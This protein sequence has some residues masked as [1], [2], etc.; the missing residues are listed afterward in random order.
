[1][2]IV[3]LKNHPT[4]GRVGDVREVP[5]GYAR[6]F[7]I[8]QGIA[9]EATKN[10][11][12]H[13][14]AVKH[15]KDV[16]KKRSGLDQK[17][18]MRALADLTLNMKEKADEKGTFFAGITKEKIAAALA[19]K[20]LNVKLKQIVLTEPV[21]HAGTYKVRIIFDPSNQVV[22]NLVVKNEN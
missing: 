18:L 11:V 16:E 21:K 22:V 14:E 9:A 8:P 19:K 6:N 10:N 4:A 13:A 15:R 20:N 17:H 12:E 2:K 5:E 1:M 3:I 7:L